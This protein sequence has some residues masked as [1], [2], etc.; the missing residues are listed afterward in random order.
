[1]RR[2]V[3]AV[4]GGGGEGVSEGEEELDLD[5]DGPSRPVSHDTMRRVSSLLFICKE[6]SL[7]RQLCI[8]CLHTFVSSTLIVFIANIYIFYRPDSGV[9][10]CARTLPSSQYIGNHSYPTA[11]H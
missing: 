9:T 6:S 4:A 7:P 10:P 1:M 11:F 8:D 5:Y 3:A 2:G